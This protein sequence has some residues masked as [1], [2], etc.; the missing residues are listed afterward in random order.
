M[1]RSSTALVWMQDILHLSSDDR[2]LQKT[3][4]SFDVSVWEFCLPLFNGAGLVVAAP[5]EHKNPSYI[6]EII[7]E[8][9]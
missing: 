3:P 9:I 6:C 1:R 2:V 5:G 7:E 8:R 4:F